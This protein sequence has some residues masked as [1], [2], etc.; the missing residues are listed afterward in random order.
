MLHKGQGLLV[1]ILA[2]AMLV[3][4]ACKER[5]M[6]DVEEVGVRSVNDYLNLCRSLINDP[7]ANIDSQFRAT[8]CLS[9]M[10]GLLDGYMATL[11][12]RAEYD[13]ADEN[14]IAIEEITE[15][16]EE[17]NELHE[18]ITENMHQKYFLCYGSEYLFNLTVKLTR[19]V[20]NL[21]IDRDK[22]NAHYVLMKELINLY[23]CPE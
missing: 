20:E 14:V 23:P 15:K 11:S 19:H 6:F 18:Q 22:P 17:D 9:Y 7:K 10:R 2:S 12:I 1:L 3:S 13:I 21:K 8:S 5:S 4:T 16:M